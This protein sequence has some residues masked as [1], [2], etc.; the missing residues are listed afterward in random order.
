MKVIIGVWQGGVALTDL[1]WVQGALQ[2][3][4]VAREGGVGVRNPAES[5]LVRIK[6]GGVVRGV[7]EPPLNSST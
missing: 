7:K 5:G 4:V 2:Q 3:S 6:E 1:S